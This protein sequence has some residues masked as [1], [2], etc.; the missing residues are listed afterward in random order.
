MPVIQTRNI[1]LM[2]YWTFVCLQ[3]FN[4][5]CIVMNIVDKLFSHYSTSI[6]CNQLWG[7]IVLYQ[8]WC[9]SL[10][11]SRLF[12]IRCS[13]LYSYKVLKCFICFLLLLNV[14]R[15]V[16]FPHEQIWLLKVSV[17]YIMSI[18]VFDELFAFRLWVLQSWIH[19]KVCKNNV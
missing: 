9:N 14:I 15:T 13:V 12:I 7:I 8:L 16:N 19:F 4:P 5:S 17:N 18:F 2:F 10:N 6:L 11:F 3:N 1:V